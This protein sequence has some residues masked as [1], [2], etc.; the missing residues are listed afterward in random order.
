MLVLTGDREPVSP[1][2]LLT[3][4][5]TQVEDMPVSS[6]YRTEELPVLCTA[7]QQE[8]NAPKEEGMEA[9]SFYNVKARFDINWNAR[10]NDCHRHTGF[11]QVF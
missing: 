1:C 3:G 7:G 11:W 9:T 8:G 6:K 5:S 4:T 2:V 10:R